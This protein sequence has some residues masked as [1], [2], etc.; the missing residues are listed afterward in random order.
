MTGILRAALRVA[1][2]RP[3]QHERISP[4]H[5]G[6]VRKRCIEALLEG[7]RGRYIETGVVKGD[8]YFTVILHKDTAA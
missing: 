2:G 1:Y 7:E 8:R 3:L 5:D 4:L 6:Q